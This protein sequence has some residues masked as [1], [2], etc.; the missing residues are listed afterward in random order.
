MRAKLLIMQRGRDG[1]MQRQDAGYR[2]IWY[3]DSLEGTWAYPFDSQRAPLPYRTRDKSM[4]DKETNTEH[5]SEHSENSPPSLIQLVLSVMAAAIG[6]QTKAGRARDFR[7]NSPLPFILAGLLFTIAFVAT[8]I[9]V[10]N[11]VL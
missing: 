5:S 7:T 3:L 1:R 6:V 9:L 10:V 2:Q 11:L 4:S 8:L